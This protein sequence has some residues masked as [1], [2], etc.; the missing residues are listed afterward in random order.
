MHTVQVMMEEIKNELKNGA[1]L[2][3]IQDR[4]G[5]SVDSHLPIYNNQIVAEWQDMP[6]EYD[7]RG[8]AEL[9]GGQEIDIINL[10]LLDLYL[11]YSDLFQ[12]AIEGVRV[13]LEE[14]AS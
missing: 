10:M 11:Y 4:A 2:E 6:S 14:V 7:N 9:G 12:T 1:T 13:D 8:H 3:E 5:E